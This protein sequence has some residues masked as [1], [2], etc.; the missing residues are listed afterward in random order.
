MQR[1]WEL[2]KNIL[3]LTQQMQKKHICGYL[4][5]SRAL[6]I[7]FTSDNRAKKQQQ[8]LQ[9]QSRK[10]H[11][12]NGMNNGNNGNMPMKLKNGARIP[13]AVSYLIGLNQSSQMPRNEW[14]MANI[15]Y[16]KSMS[17]LEQSA[18]Q[19]Y[20]NA[21]LKSTVCKMP[22]R[23]ALQPSATATATNL[24]G[25][26]IKCFASST[27]LAQ[28]DDNKVQASALS[29]RLSKLFLVEPDDEEA[30]PNPDREP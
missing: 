16:G 26:K 17:T 21:K 20:K 23:K 28:L 7:S 3:H 10:D 30:S 4:K 6:A 5:P 24:F 18:R 25:G 14:Q 15:K 13:T 1:H 12:A 22:A 27:S 29:K 9:Q 19:L 11:V 8:Q 2:Q